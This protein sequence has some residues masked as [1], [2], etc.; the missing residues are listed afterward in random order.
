M[1]EWTEIAR[2]PICPVK[3]LEE[4]LVDKE[5]TRKDLINVNKLIENL[6]NHEQELRT[7]RQEI[8]R[9]VRSIEI[10]LYKETRDV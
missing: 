4:V 8:Q 9:R 10:D 5:I 3:A 2:F 6:K 7:L 1:E